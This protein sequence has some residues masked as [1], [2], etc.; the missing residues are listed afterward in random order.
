[1]G[2]ALSVQ[3][4]PDKTLAQQLYQ[5]F[6]NIYKD[7]NHKPEMTCALTPFEALCSFRSPQEIVHFITTVPE[8]RTMIGEINVQ[9]LQASLTTTVSS[10]SSSSSSVEFSTHLRQAYH[11]MM[12]QTENIVKEQ[13]SLLENRLQ[14]QYLGLTTIEREELINKL[15]PDM[16]VL[17]LARQY[18]NDIG[19]FCPYLLNLVRLQP[20]E[21]MFLGANEPHAYL[22]GDCVEI[23]ACSDNVVRAG[24]TPKYKDIQTLCSMLT[25]YTGKPEII[26]GKVLDKYTK[27][28][29]A[30]VP[31]FLLQCTTIANNDKNKQNTENKETEQ[32]NYTLPT[33]PAAAIIIVTEGMVTLRATDTNS[34]SVSSSSS[35]AVSASDSV[36][37]VRA[38]QIWLQPANISLSIENVTH[39]GESVVM[40][41]A[42]ANTKG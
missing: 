18:P 5:N 12:S 21:A 28:Y 1:M 11:T 33:I 37:T 8:L 32:S 14:H 3:A 27:E 24:L 29:N 39:T 35:S 26:G 40:Y 19:I 34:S 7:S 13:T 2:K 9:N 10:S 31:E 38:G 20:G 41:R 23:M 30:P 16:F 25:Y 15:D 36:I 17:R 42:H 6:P 4:H 22:A